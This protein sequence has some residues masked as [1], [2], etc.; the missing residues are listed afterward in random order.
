M[1]VCV[2][3]LH[4]CVCVCV[5]SMRSAAHS[6][7]RAVRKYVYVCVCVCVC[8][9]HVFLAGASRG[10]TAQRDPAEPGGHGLCHQL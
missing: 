7:K 5:R 9:L 4:V 6:V 1:Y 2:C 8:V 3:V 10:T